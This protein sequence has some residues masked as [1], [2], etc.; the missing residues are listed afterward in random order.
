MVRSLHLDHLRL[1]AFLL[2]AQH[3][4]AAEQRFHP[5][6]QLHHAER[7][8]QI[9][10]GAHLQSQHAIQLAGLG[11]EHEDRRVAAARAQPPAHFQPVDARAA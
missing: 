2:L 8:G 11:G 4:D 5:R 10:V 1:R 3:L 7:F 6:G 9:V